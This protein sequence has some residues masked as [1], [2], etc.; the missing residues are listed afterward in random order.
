MVQIYPLSRG[1]IGLIVRIYNFRYK[2]GEKE[3][4]EQRKHEMVS[5]KI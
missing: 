1:V 3:K 2:E 5:G 4:N